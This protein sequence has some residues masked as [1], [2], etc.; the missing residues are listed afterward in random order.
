MARNIVNEVRDDVAF[1]RAS[2]EEGEAALFMT[3]APRCA[4]DEALRASNDFIM[5]REYVNQLKSSHE[6]SP[7][8]GAARTEQTNVAKEPWRVRWDHCVAFFKSSDAGYVPGSEAMLKR[9]WQFVEGLIEL[10]QMSHAKCTTCA[11]GDAKL[12]HIR[13]L[14]SKEAKLERKLIERLLIEH[15]TI[16]LGARRACK[17]WPFQTVTQES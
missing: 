6:M 9:A 13:G 15:T 16:H 5:I 1:A 3:A 7:A 10:R 12:W 4:K 14:S 17:K 2:G 8:P 11:T